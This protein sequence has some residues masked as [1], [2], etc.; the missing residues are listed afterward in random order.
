MRVVRFW[1]GC[2]TLRNKCDELPQQEWLIV[3]SRQMAIP[4]ASH[5]VGHMKLHGLLREPFSLVIF[6]EF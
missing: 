1:L 3:A 4:T 2:Y 5:P 6:I